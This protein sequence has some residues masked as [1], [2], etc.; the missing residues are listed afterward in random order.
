MRSCLA[1]NVQTLRA[2]DIQ[3]GIPSLAEFQFSNRNHDHAVTF[4]HQ[5]TQRPDIFIK[6]I[7]KESKLLSNKLISH[8]VRT[9]THWFGFGSLHAFVKAIR[10][11]A[12]SS[13]L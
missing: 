1:M 11:L 9:N 4:Y 13:I 3:H 2:V 7:R 6:A 5:L 8:E 12:L 10:F